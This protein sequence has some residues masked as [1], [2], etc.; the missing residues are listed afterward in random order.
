[1]GLALFKKKVQLKI[2]VA[3]YN[4]YCQF[5]LR[6][7]NVCTDDVGSYDGIPYH[8]GGPLGPR[9]M[10]EELAGKG[11]SLSAYATLAYVTP[12]KDR[13]SDGNETA[14]RLQASRENRAIGTHAN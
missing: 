13:W 6:P 4:Y 11:F 5:K 1:M 7:I 8:P 10:S 3:S 2:Q 9:G 14:L 12:S